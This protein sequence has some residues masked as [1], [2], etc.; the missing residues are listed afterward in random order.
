MK[1]L[2]QMVMTFDEVSENF[3]EDAASGKADGMQI[4]DYRGT[5]PTPRGYVTIRRKF[6]IDPAKYR[7]PNY[8]PLA[9]GQDPKDVQMPNGIVGME[10]VLEET[11]SDVGEG[12]ASKGEDAPQQTA[13]DAMY[14][15]LME[16]AG[17]PPVAAVVEDESADSLLCN[18][19]MPE[20]AI[21][22]DADS[23]CVAM[24]AKT[25]RK[26]KVSC[27]TKYKDCRA[28][29]P[30]YCPYHGAAL[31]KDDIVRQLRSMGVNGLVEVESGEDTGEYFY[32]AVTVPEADKQKAEGIID[33]LMKTPG[34]KQSVDTDNQSV[35]AGMT[36]LSAYFN[37]DV[38]RANVPPSQQDKGNGD[39]KKETEEDKDK[40][41]EGEDNGENEEEKHPKEEDKGEKKNEEENKKD[42]DT[43][44]PPPPPPDK[45][46]KQEETDK[47][48]AEMRK[49]ID[50]I[51]ADIS[52]CDV[53]IT[54]ARED[55][56][57]RDFDDIS[58]KTGDFRERMLNLSDS[59]KEMVEKRNE[60][61]KAGGDSVQKALNA[62]IL[63]MMM[64]TF[65]EKSIPRAQEELRNLENEVSELSAQAK[66]DRENLAIDYAKD[67]I[68][69]A[70]GAMED[71][72]FGDVAE[73]NIPIPSGLM[74]KPLGL[75]AGLINML[76]DAEKYNGDE[77]DAKRVASAL[78]LDSTMDRY[79]DAVGA[80]ESALDKADKIFKS[81][82]MS[83]DEVEQQKEE[84]LGAI[85]DFKIAASMLKEN[86]VK[87][88][89][90]LRNAKDRRDALR[91]EEEEKNKHM[92]MPTDKVLADETMLADDLLGQ[93]K[94]GTAEAIAQKDGAE[95]YRLRSDSTEGLFADIDADK[96]GKIT[97]LAITLPNRA[98]MNFNSVEA[99]K[100]AHARLFGYDRFDRNA[101]V[102]DGVPIEDVLKSE[103]IRSLLPSPSEIEMEMH[104]GG[105][106][107]EMTVKADRDRLVAERNRA[108]WEGYK[109]SE[110]RKNAKDS[111]DNANKTGMQLAELALRWVGLYGKRNY[112]VRVLETV[113]PSEFDDGTAEFGIKALQRLLP[114]IMPESVAGE[115]HIAKGKR[116]LRAF[117]GR[118]SVIHPATY[119]TLDVFLHESGHAFEFLGPRVKKRCV[120]FL[121]YRT[122]G[123]KLHT[124]RL[125][126]G[127]KYGRDEKAMKDK[128]FHP[129]CGKYY[130]R[131]GYTVN[132]VEHETSYSR[133]EKRELE[134]Q[135]AEGSISEYH[136]TSS[137]TEILSMGLQRLITQPIKFVTEDPEY[138][139]FVLGICQGA[140]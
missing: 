37:V 26:P 68:E 90:A 99:F 64:K 140:I 136:L 20:T 91:K 117:C 107:P 122:R 22:E 81:T 18:M 109:T 76:S 84:I 43:P 4:P 120:E 121:L 15:A 71:E 106:L 128:F 24:D 75:E 49:A 13:Q 119:E 46:E 60:A 73:K 112:G 97:S 77:E 131:Y 100:N 82:N 54:H 19:C 47:E 67:S 116:G 130:P 28:K 94:L 51:L 39:E 110:Y 111:F 63:D 36:E 40:G 66:Q 74:F 14:G 96:D 56:P 133:D 134:R 139:A 9:E 89:N 33:A 11:I 108:N 38:L 16:I 135:K 2:T 27:K 113:S 79:H 52:K 17:K 29:N 44:P 50:D 129:Y 34:F 105:Q 104:E 102:F 72:I 125:L 62:H 69:R 85:L 21:A 115:I 127:K 78:Y 42:E 70:V 48:I 41:E 83:A 114:R 123:E 10:E 55:A 93:L 138:A 12:D 87:A 32:L 137:C 53:S 95:R 7:S 124:L 132:G 61:I 31:I 59:F 86:Y 118:D 57:D 30:L 98:T 101:S 126:T 92:S 1:E 45:D 23:P 65:N 8:V 25:P 5:I 6:A 58:Q 80:Y 35:G 88:A 3:A 103:A